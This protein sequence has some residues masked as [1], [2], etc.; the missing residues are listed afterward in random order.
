MKHWYTLCL[1]LV[2]VLSLVLPVTAGA[3]QPVRPQTDAYGK[4]LTEW[5]LLYLTWLLG[6]DPVDHV[7]QVRFLPL[8]QGTPQGEDPVIFVA[9]WQPPWIRVHLLFCRSLL[10]S[11]KAMITAALMNR[12]PAIGS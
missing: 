8:P 11:G 2:L 3:S 7:G 10:G 6:G 12:C 1:V 9:N 5:Q 4:S